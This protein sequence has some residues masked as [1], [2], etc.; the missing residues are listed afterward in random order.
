MPR[1]L[2]FFLPGLP[3]VRSLVVVVVIVEFFFFPPQPPCAARPLLPHTR[4]R[5]RT[6]L[7]RCLGR[8]FLQ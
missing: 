1:M 7:L 4:A 5:I 6:H 2:F 8:E 3:L